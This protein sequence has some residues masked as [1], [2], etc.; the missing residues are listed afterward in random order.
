MVDTEI[1][2]PPE[3]DVPEE[4][5][6]PLVSEAEYA[7]LREE[8]T[9]EIKSVKKVR[10]P[11]RM[12]LTKFASADQVIKIISVGYGV[13]VSLPRDVE[14]AMGLK[15][16]QMVRMRIDLFPDDAAKLFSTQ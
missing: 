5:D 11:Y 3:V 4:V 6:I 14:I 9:N 8:I 15:R 1:E 16:G 13:G 7:R 2:L 12:P 10:P